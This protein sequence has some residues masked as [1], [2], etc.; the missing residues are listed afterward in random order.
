[1]QEHI[2]VGKR[3]PGHRPEHVLLVRARRPGVRRRLRGGRPARASSTSC[4]ACA[5]RRPRAYTKRDTPTFTCVA[6]SVERALSALDGTPLRRDGPRLRMPA[7]LRLLA[8]AVCALALVL[9]GCGGDDDDGGSGARRTP[10]PR[11][12]A[13]CRSRSAPPRTPGVRLPGDRAAGRC[14][15]SRTRSAAARRWAWPA[16][17]SARAR[18]TGS[19]SASSTT[20]RA[21]S[22]ARRRSTSRSRPT[23][24]AKGPFPAPADMLVTDPPYRSEQ[25]ATEAD[26]FAAVYAAH[27]LLGKPGAVRGHGRHA[28]RRQAGR[29]ARADPDDRARRTTRSRRSA[30]RRRRSQ[31]DTVASRRR[32]RRVD[33]HAPA[34]SDMHEVDFADVVGKK[35]VALL[36]ATP[37]LC[38]SRVCGPV[39]DDRAAAQGEVRRPDRLHPPGGLRGQRSEQGPA[40]AAAGSSGSQTEPWLFVV[41]QGRA[42]SPRG[43]RAPSGSTRSSRRSRPRCE[44][45]ARGWR[46][47]PRRRGAPRRARAAQAHGLVQR[48]T[49]RSRSGCS[50]GRRRSCSSRRSPA[51]AVL[52]PTPRLQEP[53]L[54]PAAAASAACSAAARWS[55]CAAR[56]ASRCSWSS[57]IAG[58]AGERLGA[59]QP[60]ADVHPDHFW[61][62]LAFA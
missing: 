24:P 59:R 35:P 18:R 4:S 28:R 49:C 10:S 8:A 34:D 62:G 41:G 9:A 15:S 12:R 11:S 14:R 1:M 5:R 60:R 47:P 21:S 58:F 55:G 19:P 39:V 33:R 29:R 30:T 46:S 2:K 27:V 42:R 31:T 37:Q 52:W 44:H 13:A 53:P 43:S 54:A 25:A 23:S 36:F 17:S 16:R 20:R 22:T 57:C 3:V 32:R 45:A 56:S 26:P 61:V 50:A 7:V 38:Q 48:R 40:R 51:L 6:A